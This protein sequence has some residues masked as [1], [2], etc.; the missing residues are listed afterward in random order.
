[1]SRDRL[2]KTLADVFGFPAFRPAMQALHHPPDLRAVEGDTIARRRVG[3]DELLASQIALALVR[4]QQ[5][6]MA[7]RVTAGDGA[8][9]RAIETALPASAEE[10]EAI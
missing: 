7:G 8:L 9:R 5:K 4:R 1:M 6:K 3:Y 10:R 2:E